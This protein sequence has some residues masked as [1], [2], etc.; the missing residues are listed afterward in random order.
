MIRKQNP[1]VL[2]FL[3]KWEMLYI[4]LSVSCFIV[5]RHCNA[6]DSFGNT[7]VDTNSKDEFCLDHEGCIS[8]P[9]VSNS[10]STSEST[11]VAGAHRSDINKWKDSINVIIT[12]TNAPTN[13]RL[14]VP[15]PF[16]KL[17]A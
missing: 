8:S 12:F 9:T 7:M 3:L 4:I 17:A 14:Q 10:L 13:S 2:T 15:F 6:D 1:L 11:N 16:I 5:V